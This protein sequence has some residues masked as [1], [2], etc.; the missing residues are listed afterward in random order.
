MW[1]TYLDFLQGL[2][3][4]IVLEIATVSCVWF[5]F[6]L[7]GFIGFFVVGF[8]WLRYFSRLGASIIILLMNSFKLHAPTYFFLSS[9]SF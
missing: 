1:P 7:L 2:R 6:A 4:S 8:H 9:I 3:P 5:Q